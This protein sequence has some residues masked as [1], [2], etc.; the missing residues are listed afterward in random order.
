MDAAIEVASRYCRRD[1]GSVMYVPLWEDAVC[2]AALAI[3]R[4]EDPETQVR[5]FV[6]EERGWGK[7]TCSMEGVA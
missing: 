7:R 6:R 3:C 5:D 2:V 1:R 4:G